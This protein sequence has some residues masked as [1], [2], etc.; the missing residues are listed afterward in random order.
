MEQSKPATVVDFHRAAYVLA[1]RRIREDLR[2][3]HEELN[4]A[5][6]EGL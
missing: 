6:R 2:R 1:L 4:Q 5:M 3:W